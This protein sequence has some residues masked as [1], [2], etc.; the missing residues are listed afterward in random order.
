MVM[1]GL[2]LTCRSICGD[3]GDLVADYR[4]KDKMQYC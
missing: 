1:S 2:S 3:V 4:S